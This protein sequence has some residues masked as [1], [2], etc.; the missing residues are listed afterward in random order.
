MAQIWAKTALTLGR[1]VG[2]E[3]LLSEIINSPTYNFLAAI[4]QLLKNLEN[5]SGAN[6]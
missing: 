1:R 4:V 2:D 3:G 6:L 5:T